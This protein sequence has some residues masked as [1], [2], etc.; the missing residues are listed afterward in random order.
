MGYR[1]T[2]ALGC[3]FLLARQ[4]TYALPS[5]PWMLASS[6][7]LAGGC[8]VFYLTAGSLAMNSLAGRTVRATAQTLLT[9]AGPGLGQMFAHQVTGYLVERAGVGMEGVFAFASGCVALALVLLALLGR[10]GLFDAAPE[11][12]ERGVTR[13]P[14]RR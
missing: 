11:A 2:L 3:A 14:V 1:G 6:Y 10:K 12:P 5:P 4:L 8:V 9:L 7:V 13:E